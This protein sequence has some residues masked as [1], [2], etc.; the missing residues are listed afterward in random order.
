MQLF[1][2]ELVEWQT[3]QTHIRLLHQEQS[4][5]GLHC[6]QI[7]FF[8]TFGVRNFRTFTVFIAL[9]KVL[10]FFQFKSIDILF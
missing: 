6:L 7:S 9:D 3:V 2:K 8:Q 1:L 10:F 4:D 5:M